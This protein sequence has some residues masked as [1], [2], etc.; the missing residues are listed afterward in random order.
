MNTALIS[1]GLKCPYPYILFSY[2][3]NSKEFTAKCFLSLSQER[4]GYLKR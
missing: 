2:Y 3:F 1:L 4:L